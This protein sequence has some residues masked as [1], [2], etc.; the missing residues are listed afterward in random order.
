LNGRVP[1]STDARKPGGEVVA[2]LD[3]TVTSP[4]KVEG[5]KLGDRT[6]E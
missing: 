3:Y 2:K 6:V 1:I 4:G 5:K